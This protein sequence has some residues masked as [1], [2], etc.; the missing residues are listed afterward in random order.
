MPDLEEVLKLPILRN[1]LGRQVTMVIDDGLLR[2]KLVV[3]RASYWSLKK[4][5]VVDERH[6]K[7]SICR[8]GCLALSRF[9]ITEILKAPESDL[10][11]R[12]HFR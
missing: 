9:A 8:F 10:R 11:Q 5:V 1:I 4:E 7:E 6:N 12:V 2:R 3:E